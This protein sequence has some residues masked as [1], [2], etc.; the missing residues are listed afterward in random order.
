[1][2]RIVIAAF[3]PKQGMQQRLLDVVAKHWRVLHERNLVTDRPR[4]AMQAADG[5]VVEVFEWRSA[6]AVAQAHSDPVV[7]ALWSEFEEV[8][9]Y[10]PVADVPE[11]Q[12]LFSE[13]SALIF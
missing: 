4:I 9:D 7:L 8:C 12:R 13:F 10:V 6:E 3:R 5:T 2:S 11:S 1:M